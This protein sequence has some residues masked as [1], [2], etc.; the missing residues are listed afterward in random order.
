MEKIKTENLA[1]RKVAKGE[2]GRLDIWYWVLG[3]WV[4]ENREIGKL[5]DWETRK[6]GDWEN[7]LPRI[8]DARRRLQ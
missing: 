2:R 3:D 7:G 5:G 6:L 1:S 4:L 8:V